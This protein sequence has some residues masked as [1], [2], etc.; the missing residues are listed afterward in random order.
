MKHTRAAVLNAYADVAAMISDAYDRPNC[1]LNAVRVTIDALRKFGVEV[2]PVSVGVKAR[3]VSGGEHYL[4]EIDT[5]TSN[6]DVYPGHVV[7]VC[8]EVLIDPSA[9]QFNRPEKGIRIPP[10]FMA[11]VNDSFWKGEPAAFAN[12]SGTH[13]QYTPRLEDKEFFTTAGFKRSPQNLEVLHD[14]VEAMRRKLKPRKR[15]S[16]ASNPNQK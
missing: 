12:A 11:T 3:G 9:G 8:G 13:I 2:R 7:G 15:T 10:V 16:D 6:A 4:V 14:V 1:C 5:W